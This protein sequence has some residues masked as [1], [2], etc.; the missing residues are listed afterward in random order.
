MLLI[1]TVWGWRLGLGTAVLS[2]LAF[3]FFHLPP[4]GRLDVRADH[5]L[6]ALVV[7]VIVAIAGAARAELARAR[8]AEAERRREEAD[9]A[10]AELEQLERE[11]DRMRAE[12]IEAEALRRSD[13]LKT[14]LLRSVS[15]DLRT[16][17]TSIIAAGAALDSPGATP[18]ERH[19]L[20]EAVVE[21]GR[22]LSRLVE[23][24]IDV[25]PSPGS[26]APHPPALHRHRDLPPRRRRRAAAGAGRERDPDARL[27]GAGAEEPA[28]GVLDPQGGR[29]GDGDA[30]GDR[31]ARRRPGGPGRRPDRTRPLLRHALARLLERESFDR[32]VVSATADGGEGL[33][34]DDLVWL[35]RKAPAEVLILRPAPDDHRRLEASANGAGRTAHWGR[36]I[37]A[38]SV[39]RVPS[40]PRSLRP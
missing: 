6:V 3:N 40:T 23:N 26:S 11:R 37:S 39:A 4:L 10:L 8:A 25:S 35:L 34:G 33:S 31:T 38:S 9:R 2:A 14:S 17:L 5:D 21:Q 22:R 36:R 18:A 19:E 12:A 13:E 32:V 16:P 15:H 28:A 27:P 1:A 20:S 29:Q 24:L 7:F 30:G